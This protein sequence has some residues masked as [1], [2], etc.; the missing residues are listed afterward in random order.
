ARMRNTRLAGS[1][2]D[3]LLAPMPGELSF[4]INR[5]GVASW[6]AVTDAEA[7]AAVAFA[8]R[9]LKLVAEPGGAV[10][11]ALALS[12]RLIQPGE[13]VVVVI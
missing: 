8:A 3:A 1:I 6:G 7:L 12:G 10:A 2:A 11:L 4:A 9:E 13:T 5:S